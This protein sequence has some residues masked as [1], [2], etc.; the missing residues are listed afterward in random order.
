[1]HVTHRHSFPAIFV[2]PIKVSLHRAFYFI[3]SCTMIWLYIIFRLYNYSHT[4]MQETSDA[5]FDS[6]ANKI[7]FLHQN[8]SVGTVTDNVR[9]NKVQAQFFSS[10][11]RAMH[12]AE[13]N[14]YLCCGV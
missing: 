7:L 11:S 8:K 5:D 13:K 14:D 12:E 10:L 4:L 6:Y 1:M 3:F 2:L 9:T